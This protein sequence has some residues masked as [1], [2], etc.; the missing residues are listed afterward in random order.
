MK[1]L[2]NYFIKYRITGNVLMVLILLFGI[3]GMMNMR[4]TFFP[5]VPIRKVSIQVVYPSASAEEIEESVVLKIEDQL[6]GVTGIER[7]TST[8]REN[9]ATLTVEMKKSANIEEVLQD[10]KNAVDQINS[11]PTGVETIDVFKREEVNVAVTFAITGSDDLYELKRISRKIER[12][13][14]STEGISKVDVSGF[15]DEEIAIEFKEEKLRAYGVTMEQVLRRIKASNIEVTGGTIKGEDEE[16]KIRLKNKS[17][18][19]IELQN[20]VVISSIDGRVV[21]LHEVAEVSDKWAEAP[22]RNFLNGDPAVTLDVKYTNDEDLLSI[23]ENVKIYIAEFNGENAVMDI[24]IVNDQSKTVQERIDML[25]NNGQIGFILVLLLLAMFLH[26]RLAFWVALSIPIAFAGMFILA[27]FFGIT[28]NV[29]SLFGMIT[30]IGILV[31]DGVVISENIYR[32]HEMGKNRVKAAIDGTMEVAPA[33]FSAI[34][35]TII[36]FST[37]FFV[38]GRLGDFFGEMAFIV[39]ATLIFSLVEGLFILPAHVAHSKALDRDAKPNKIMRGLTSAMEWLKLKVYKPVLEF[40]LSNPAFAIAV[41]VGLLIITFGALSGGVI[42]ST[43]FP[44]IEAD[45]ISVNFK[46]P[47][48]TREHITKDHL[49]FIEASVWE[50]NEQ[51]KEERGDD[52]NIIVSVDKRIGPTNGHL[53]SLRIELMSGDERGV[54]NMEVTN[55]IRALVG[56]IPGAEEF[57]FGTGNPFGK[58][59]SISLRGDDMEELR[60]VIDLLKAEMNSL[61][62]LKDITDNDLRGTKEV[63]IKLKDKAYVLGLTEQDIIGQIRRGFFGGEVQRI[64]RGL[65][66]VKVWVR[67]EEGERSTI[68]QLKNVV[69]RTQTGGTNILSDLVDFSVQRGVVGINHTDGKREIIVEADIASEGV[70]AT[71]MVANVEG[72]ILP[73]ILANFPDIEYA[74]EGQSREQQ[75]SAGSMKAVMPI[76]LILMIAVIVFTFRSFSQTLVVLLLIPFGFIGV[77]WGHYIHGMQISL[78]SI[79]GT[80]ALIGILINDSLVF[81]SAFNVN[82]KARMPYKEALMTAALSRFRPIVLT[83]I[84]TIAGLAPLIQETSFQAQFLIPMALSI[85]YGLAVATMVIL[86]ILPVLLLIVNNGKRFAHWYWY[87]KKPERKFL[88]PAYKELEYEEVGFESGEEIEFYDFEETG[89]D[90][91]E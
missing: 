76:I 30:V 18:R 27:S 73:D 65:D 42:S 29:I 3:V 50:V 68:K 1:G 22:D 7:V 60:T 90:T 43:F 9:T 88:E 63:L 87:D 13:L 80:I 84:T 46:M 5:Q 32:H 33:V 82:I 24:T 64:Q 91:Y 12:D 75:K 66:E 16:F 47:A 71:D 41:P 51:F 58:P 36:V 6:T 8:S 21:K 56:E 53:G 44:T 83:S 70:S 20:L 89:Y 86:V 79:L 26:Y 62:D 72:K 52:F 25:V 61:T 4:S 37:F 34:L 19:G 55:R 45:N 48:G 10:V 14:L 85:A 28:I 15:P 54:K 40:S 74:F 38:E 57:N 78:F 67:Y 31:D 2:V 77:A 11:F 59:V 35:T 81:V 49:D 39:I 23:V 17:Y 69:I